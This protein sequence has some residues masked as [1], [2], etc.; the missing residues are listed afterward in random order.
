MSDIT[1]T[2]DYFLERIADLEHQLA[3][4]KADNLVLMRQLNEQDIAGQN[5]YRK[6]RDK[7]S[8]RDA[9]LAELAPTCGNCAGIGKLDDAEPGDIYFNEFVCPLCNGT[10]KDYSKLPATA[11]A[12]AKI[13]AAAEEQ[14]CAFAN[15]P[16]LDTYLTF[17]YRTD[18]AVR[19]K[20]NL[21]P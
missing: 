5:M 3:S 10:G 19:E 9:M 15:S 2:Q 11:K 14:A 20:K 12:N 16:D 18:A 21:K 13:I 6:E 8:E 7:V 17:A 4:A 1:E